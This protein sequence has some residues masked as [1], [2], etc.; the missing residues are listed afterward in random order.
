MPIMW[1]V[2]YRYLD[3]YTKKNL[4]WFELHFKIYTFR[5]MFEKLSKY[6]SLLSPVVRSCFFI[7]LEVGLF[8]EAALLLSDV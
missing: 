8:L 5:C 6:L 3:V 1:L 2:M 7:T 4:C